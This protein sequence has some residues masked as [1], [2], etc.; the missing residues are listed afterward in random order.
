[1]I[2]STVKKLIKN[3][4]AQYQAGVWTIDEYIGYKNTQQNKLDVFFAKGRLTQ[5]QYEELT[6]MW[7]SVND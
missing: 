4:N 5:L 1:M 2:Y 7:L 3:A 6:G